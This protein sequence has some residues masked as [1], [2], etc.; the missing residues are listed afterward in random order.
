MTCGPFKEVGRVKPPVSV[1]QEPSEGR[2]IL[3]YCPYLL[4]IEMQIV[5]SMK[6]FQ[7]YNKIEG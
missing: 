1:T 2:I 7:C 4:E 3:C 5:I 6:T